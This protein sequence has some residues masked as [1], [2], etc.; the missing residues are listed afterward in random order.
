[1]AFPTSI[2]NGASK[3]ALAALAAAFC[4]MGAV[5]GA[6]AA[7][8]RGAYCKMR[9]DVRATEVT[10]PDHSSSDNIPL[11]DITTRK[12]CGGPVIVTFSAELTG[13][14]HIHEVTA[15]CLDDGGI[16]GGCIAGTIKFAPPAHT[17]LQSNG[18]QQVSFPVVTARWIFPRLGV[19]NWRFRIFPAAF[20]PAIV[21]NSAFTVE[22]YD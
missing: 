22:A 9:F 17:L 4:L 13:T 10:I 2:M 5:E 7:T 15:V 18:E 3:L 11:G 12:T 6:A 20:A 16:Q 1:M 8:V 14:I 21:K 19:G